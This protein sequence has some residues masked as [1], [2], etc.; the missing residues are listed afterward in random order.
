MLRHVIG[1]GALGGAPSFIV[2]SNVGGAPSGPHPSFK[3][4]R[5]GVFGSA[6][7]Y[8]TFQ[9]KGV[10]VTTAW[11]I[12]LQGK[13]TQAMLLSGRTTATSLTGSM[14]VPISLLGKVPEDL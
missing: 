5:L 8:P 7:A 3:I 9:P 2:Y 6:G 1:R 12:L 14:I 11:T 10:V 13:T 4:T